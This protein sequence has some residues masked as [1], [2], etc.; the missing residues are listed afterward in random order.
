MRLRSVFPPLDA[1]KIYTLALEIDL[2]LYYSGCNRHFRHTH[3]L[4]HS[5]LT[6]SLIL[7]HTPLPTHTHIM[8]VNVCIVFD[9]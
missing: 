6:H 7:T 1:T 5:S 8:M 9:L 2:G 4:T 3:S